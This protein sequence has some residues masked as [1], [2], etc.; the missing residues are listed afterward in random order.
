MIQELILGFKYE[1][2]SKFNLQLCTTYSVKSGKQYIKLKDSSCDTRFQSFTK[3]Y[4]EI[5]H[6]MIASNFEFVKQQS[7]NEKHSCGY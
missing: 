7:K 2:P 6:E 4:R 3:N 5:V 1:D